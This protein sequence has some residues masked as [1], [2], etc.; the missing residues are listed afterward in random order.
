MISIKNKWVWDFW[1]TKNNNLYFCYFLQANKSL[2]NPD[3]RHNNVTQGLATSTD[4]INWEY[5]GTV[6]SPSEVENFDD[7]TTWTGSILKD[8]NSKWHYFYTGRNKKDKGAKQRIGHAHGNTPYSFERCGNGMALDLDKEIYEE[9]SENGYWKDRAMRDPWV[10]KHPL[11]NKYIMAYTARAS[12]NEDP[13]QCGVIGMAESNDLYEWKSTKPLFGGLFSQLEVPQIFTFK[14]RWY[15]LFCN[16]PEDW[17]NEFKK[18]Y[19]GPTKRGTHYLIADKFEGPWQLAPGPYLTTNS[20]VELYAGRVVEKD[21]K[22]FFMAFLHNDQNDNFIGEISNPIP[23]TF[24]KN[25]LM[26]LEF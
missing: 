12:I 26:S 7:Y 8:K 20:E 2:V 9:Y 6:F 1:L 4:L 5:Y 23:I 10:M 21:D 19:N 3:L 16:H 13:Y 24:D 11:K 17:S 14:D 25:G 22:Y 18:N 15:C